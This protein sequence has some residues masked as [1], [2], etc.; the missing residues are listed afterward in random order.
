VVVGDLER[1]LKQL[2]T[3]YCEH[4]FFIKRN[5]F[6]NYNKSDARLYIFKILFTWFQKDKGQK[7]N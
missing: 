1:P 2:L 5:V 7:N 4:N 6:Q 3:G